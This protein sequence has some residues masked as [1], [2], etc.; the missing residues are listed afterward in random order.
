MQKNVPKYTPT[1]V[2]TVQRLGRGVE[3]RGVVRAVQRPSHAALVR[4]PAGGRVP[5]DAGDGRPPR[6]HDPPR[7]S[8]SIHPTATR[9]RWR[10]GSRISCARCSPTSGSTARSRP[11]APRACT[12]SCRS[13]TTRRRRTPRPRSRAIAARVERLDPAIA[14]TAFMKEDRGGKVFVDA[15][16]VGGATV[17]AAYS[18][19]VRPGRA[20]VVPGRLGRPRRRR[21]G[22]FT[23]HTAL[24][25]AR[26]R[27]SVGRRGWPSPQRSATTLIEEGRAIPVPRVA[28]DARRQAPRPRPPDLSARPTRMTSRSIDYCPRVAVARSGFQCGGQALERPAHRLAIAKRAVVDAR[29]L[30]AELQGATRVGGLRSTRSPG[31]PRRWARCGSPRSRSGSRTSST[32]T[33]RTGR[34]RPRSPCPGWSIRVAIAV[35][36]SKVALM[37]D[38]G[39]FTATRGIPRTTRP[40]ASRRRW[41]RRRLRGGGDLRIRSWVHGAI[42]H[43]DTSEWGISI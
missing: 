6:P 43:A 35:V 19:R 28:G 16:R 18:P 29:H 27:R 1:W 13:T 10:C 23:I 25:S 12:C 5:P 9:S 33:P 40:S 26:R 8:T 20:G 7:A 41:R 22:D 15:T 24:G 30:L 17:V 21:A 11:A 42:S 38:R 2:R 3:A 31:I 39:V 14:T 36:A 34:D 32:R 37:R 4:E